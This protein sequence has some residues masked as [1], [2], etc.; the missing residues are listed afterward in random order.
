MGGLQ[1]IVALVQFV[2]EIFGTA[3]FI[4]LHLSR[5]SGQD[6]AARAAVRGVGL[7]VEAADL[8]VMVPLAVRGH[9]G[10]DAVVSVDVPR[11]SGFFGVVEHDLA[12]RRF[13]R[14]EAVEV[15]LV[16]AVASAIRLFP[17]A[18]L[19]FDPAGD[20]VADRHEAVAQVYVHALDVGVEVVGAVGSLICLE[21]D[22]LRRDASLDVHDREH[23]LSHAI[24]R[25]VAV[26]RREVREK[27]FHDRIGAE[28]HLE[29]LLK[30]RGFASKLVHRFCA[31]HTVRVSS[32]LG[33]D[34]IAYDEDSSATMWAHCII[35]N[36]IYHKNGVLSR[37]G[38]RKC[39]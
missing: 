2:E 23:A 34:H 14:R 4:D 11:P 37:V 26:H 25:G 35:D 12:G 16:I 20:R 31:L 1:L 6:G 13:G 17:G 9:V 27:T 5:S 32:R 36:T 22:V 38:R 39:P 24:V 8:E 30:E 18:D 3:P 15:E 7:D 33:F 19:D 10:E 29:L 21:L 28:A